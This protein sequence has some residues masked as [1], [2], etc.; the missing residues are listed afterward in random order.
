[1]ER[2][3]GILWNTENDCFEFNVIFREKPNK[4][5]GILSMLSSIYDPLGFIG[6]LI[7]GGRRIT[8][9]LC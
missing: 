5:R 7:L 4:C 8:Q 2:A 9:T 3:L 1:M 6:L